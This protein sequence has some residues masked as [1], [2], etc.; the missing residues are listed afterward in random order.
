MTG[1]PIQETGQERADDCPNDCQ[2]CT[3]CHHTQDTGDEGCQ[4][5]PVRSYEHRCQY[6][7]EVLELTL[8][9]EEMAAFQHSCDVIRT[10]I[11]YIEEA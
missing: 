11:G 1:F 5:S 7:D 4:K 10:N 2:C 9:P 3:P 6:I 8:T